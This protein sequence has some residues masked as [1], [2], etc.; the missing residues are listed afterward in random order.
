MKPVLFKVGPLAINSWGILVGLGILAGIALARKRAREM[1]VE[2]E[3]VLDLAFYIIIGGLLGGRL[4]YLTFY[5]LEVIANPISIVKV[6]EGGMSIH[7][8]IIGGLVAGLIFTKRKGLDFWKLADL[9]SPS[10]ILGQAIGRIG[11]FL[12][13]DSYGTATKLP[14][15]VKFPGLEGVRHPAQL[16]EMILD[17]IVFAILWARRDK[18]AFKGELFFDYVISYSIVRALVEFFRDSPKV[19]GPISPAQIASVAAIVTA[20]VIISIVKRSKRA[21]E[22]RAS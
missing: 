18:T 5:P 12:N 19:L 20:T 17:F 4:L 8:G 7:G 16:Y 15:G 22:Q 9:V 1:R 10:L 3:H 11:C 21:R 6:W 2:Y 13:G 14:W